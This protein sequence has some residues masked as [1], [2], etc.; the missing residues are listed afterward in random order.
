M[1]RAQELDP[2]SLIIGTNLGVTFVFARQCDTA[3]EQLR[4]A[5]VLDP[6]FAPARGR[7]SDVLQLKGLT[8]EAVEHFWQSPGASEMSEQ[9]AG[10]FAHGWNGSSGL[11]PSAMSC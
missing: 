2:P 11:T 9:Q 1:P 7:L 4:R 8:T 5:L 6:H 10:G 3:I